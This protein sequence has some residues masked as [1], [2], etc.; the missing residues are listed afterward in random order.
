[1]LA[2]FRSEPVAETPKILL[3]NLI[4]DGLDRKTQTAS[5]SYPDKTDYATSPLVC[6][7]DNLVF[8]RRDPQRP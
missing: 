5:P 4:E 6:A 1:M 2:S 8:Q 3:V 7:L